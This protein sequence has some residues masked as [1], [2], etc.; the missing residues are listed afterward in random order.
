MVIAALVGCSS[1]PIRPRSDAG[2]ACPESD[3]ACSDSAPTPDG[4]AETS[5]ASDGAVSRLCDGTSQ[6]R[7][8]ALFVPGMEPSGSLVRVE[9]GYP[10]LLVDGK[11][12]YWVNGGWVD[13]PLSRDRAV[14]TGALD[15]ANAEALTRAIP[16]TSVAALADCEPVPGSF[17]VPARIIRGVL[18]GA[19]CDGSGALFDSAWTAISTTAA[20]LWGQ[21]A[22]VNGPLHIS[23]VQVPSGVLKAPPYPWPIALPLKSFLIDPNNTGSTLYARGVSFPVA[24]PSVEEALRSLRDLYLADRTAQPGVYAN[25]DGLIATDQETTAYVYMRDAVP[26]E[27]DHG[28]LNF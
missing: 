1:S 7:L 2:P 25:W 22:P 12:N 14:R 23:A 5:E 4:G 26:Y 8:W 17:D 6:L 11:C 19:T 21:G 10:F 18:D 20:S 24:D 28:L 3:G 15:D 9:L 27:D 16:L 13:D